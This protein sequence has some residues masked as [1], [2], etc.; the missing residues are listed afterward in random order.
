MTSPGA[1]SDIRIVDLTQML[2]GPYATMM[3]AE[4]S[5]H[6]E[7]MLAYLLWIGVVGWGLNFA[8]TSAQRR[9]FGRSAQVRP[10]T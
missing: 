1:L 5:L 10:A 9:L 8:I 7:L 4:Q 2:S 3:L 6:P